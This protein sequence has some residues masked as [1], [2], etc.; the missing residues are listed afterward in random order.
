MPE[1]IPESRGGKMSTSTFGRRCAPR[2]ER[3]SIGTGKA[4]R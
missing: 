4:P 1:L 3:W 2:H